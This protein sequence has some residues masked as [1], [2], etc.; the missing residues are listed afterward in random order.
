M[1]YRRDQAQKRFSFFYQ[2]NSLAGAFGGLLAAAIGSMN[3]VGGYRGWRWIFILE[4]AVTIVAA[5]I[6]YFLLPEFPEESKWL[7]EEEKAYLTSR[8]RAEQGASSHEAKISWFDVKG[9]FTD[10]KMYAS[11]FMYMGLVVVAYAYS[12][13]APG[14]IKTYGYDNIQ[15]QLLSAPPWA[16]ACVV[17]MIVAYFSDKTQHR[18]GFTILGSFVSIIG[19]S[20]LVAIFNNHDFQYGGL[21]MVISGAYIALP[22]VIC[23]F[24][25]NLGG[26]QRRGI[27]SAWQIGFGN[28][29]G[30]IAS[31]AFVKSDGPK[32]VR[33]YSLCYSFAALTMISCIVYAA[34]CY[35]QNK[36]RD[37]EVGNEHGLTQEEKDRLGDLSPDYRYLL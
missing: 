35:T 23:W 22:I 19:F 31:F 15:T 5:F 32:F 2:S 24:N 26:H 11:G 36:K 13:F 33:G 18:F 9:M 20:I 12:F 10:I 21:V 25:M 6:F 7:S 30:I 27:G 17:S 8:L 3:G 37:R 1:W 14:I 16:S 4:G 29:G 28:I 34:S